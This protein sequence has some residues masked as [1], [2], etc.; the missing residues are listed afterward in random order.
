MRH[1][2]DR[3]SLTCMFALCICSY[4]QGVRAFNVRDGIG[5]TTF[6]HDPVTGR[7]QQIRFSAD[8]RYF[9]VVTTRG[10]L[11]S[12]QRESTIWLFET[13]AVQE[14]LTHT[15]R[16]TN[17]LP[18]PLV[19]MSGPS[20]HDQINDDSISDVQWSEDGKQVLFLGRNGIAERHLY[21][22]S[23]E[24]GQLQELS[25]RGQEVKEFLERK[26]IFVYAEVEP[27]SDSEMYNASDPTLPDVQVATGFSL[28]GLLF[29]R[30]AE[31]FWE[32]RLR[33]IWTVRHGV[34]TPLVDKSANRIVSV[35]TD[36]F[37][38]LCS[39]SP[40]GRYLLIKNYAQRVP[41]LWQGYEPAY[42]SPQTRIVADNIDREPRFD[43]LRPQQYELLN[44]Q[45]GDTS[46]L[47]NAPIGRVAGYNYSDGCPAAWSRDEHLVAVPNTFLPLSSS[48]HDD[49]RRPC[50]AEIDILT[51]KFQCVKESGL[52][53]L[54]QG[55]AGVR[56]LTD[57]LFRDD[58]RILV[59]R[60]SEF[61]GADLV[62][63]FFEK[64]QEH[65]TEIHGSRTLSFIADLDNNGISVS[66]EETVNQPPVLSAVTKGG[67]KAQRI[68]NPNPQVSNI[69]LGDAGLYS[70]HNESGDEWIG[71][72]VKPPNYVPGR[73]YPLV[74]QTHGFNQ[75]EF[76][77]DG[78]VATANS[79]RALASR[80]IM[81]L[82]VGEIPRHFGSPEEAEL[83]G[84]AAYEAAIDQL[85]K[86]GLVDRNRVGIIGFS[87]TGWYVLDSLIRAPKDFAVASLAE[88]SSASYWQYLASCDFGSAEM[89]KQLAD[90]IGI[91][92]FGDG[93]LR[94][95]KISPGFNTDK[96][97]VPV[98][99]ESN[100][101][102][103]LIN[104]WDIYAALR[105]QR[106]PVELLYFRNGDHV[107]TEPKQQLVSQEA[108]VDWFDFWLNG[109]EDPN[110]LKA[111]QYTRWHLLRA[112]TQ[113]ASQAP[114]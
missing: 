83:D 40:N 98:L 66:V 36:W 77:V 33:K 67:K 49:H 53:D 92:P 110:P 2:F 22:V 23:V 6:A 26:G 52:V 59:A 68:W 81:V 29:P 25:R 112:R 15:E 4:A 8:H 84:R 90:E 5:M 103:A 24:K 21:A 12:N 74:I 76:L 13:D 56:A 93:L 70:W 9:L 79:A 50:I 86:Q 31:V 20:S 30:S 104:Y 105:L 89:S 44:L 7:D 107:L 87:H 32:K 102:T 78:F 111:Y 19:R 1:P 109:H 106:K 34:A 57:L 45:T 72:L 96:I 73:R 114:R 54:S 10:N 48:G 39:I 65:W 47:V 41:G 61:Q 113:S 43:S 17:V 63:E 18:R 101:P 42:D 80:G 11:T 69:A 75:N 91:E 35:H 46:I 58:D 108:N 28:D 38:A 60:Y 97:M 100:Y 37:G 16:G 51:R 94:W 64:N 82:Q 95:V 99:L 14:F 27:V 88:F 71:G 3:L 85:A 55:A 62:P